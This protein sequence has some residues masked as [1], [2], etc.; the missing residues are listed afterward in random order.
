MT[1]TCIGSTGGRGVTYVGGGGTELGALFAS[2]PLR[3]LVAFRI[4]LRIII[5]S[6]HH[7][8]DGV[9][10]AAGAREDIFLCVVL[11]TLPFVPEEVEEAVAIG[12]I[13]QVTWRED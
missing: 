9:L 1:T 3:V 8:T 7:M 12:I 4:L 5:T 11:V 2:S 13:I 10:Y 6:A